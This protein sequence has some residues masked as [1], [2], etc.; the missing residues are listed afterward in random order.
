MS[1]AH[2]NWLFVGVIF[3]AIL[4][5]GRP[6]AIMANE[7]FDLIADAAGFTIAVLGLLMRVV[8]RDWKLV[9]GQDTLVTT[10]PY[11]MVRNPMYVGS[12][13]AGFGICL[14][15]GSTIFAIIFTV[16][17]FAVHISIARREK[18]YLITCWPDEYSQ[19]MADVPEWIPSCKRIFD[20]LFRSGRHL[21]TIPG[22]F[23][24]ER[25]SICGVLIGACLA[26]VA[27]DTIL[28]GWA[29]THAEAIILLGVVFALSLT[30]IVAGK[31]YNLPGFAK[32]RV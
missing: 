17:F 8:S 22:A 29:R 14:V 10:G 3:I 5:T 13:L 11:S 23:I 9:H 4:L 28:R 19:Y 16:C 18:R 1:R 30:W 31:L 20:F 26:E 32:Y 7:R 25:S 21:S 2:E 24:R 15:L 12:F 27:A 6:T